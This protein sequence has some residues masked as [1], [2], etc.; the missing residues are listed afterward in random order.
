MGI[1][2]F[3][4][5]P[6]AFGMVLAAPVFIP[7]FLGEAFEGAVLPL[8]IMAFV[9]VAIGFN[10]LTGVQVLIGLGYDKLFLYSVLSGAFL[11][12]VLNSIFI[13]ELGASGAA[14][15]SVMAE[16]L[17]LFITTYFV[18]KKTKVRL[19]GGA[20][21]LKSFVGG[22]TLFP[23]SYI[24][25]EYIHGW[26]YVISLAIVGCCFYILSQFLM[27]SYSVEL[28]IDII[29]KKIKH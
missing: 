14:L 20:D 24:L 21:I 22:L 2:S 29:K 8:Q 23:I 28:F 18:Y 4:A 25:G 9:I 16:T 6:M 17:I 15:A 19:S 13:P 3:L 5:I 11:N 7:L 12:F 10:N 27:K 1:I 26:L